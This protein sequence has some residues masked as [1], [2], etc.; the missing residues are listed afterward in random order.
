[1]MPVR[2]DF[3]DYVM[4]AVLNFETDAWDEVIMT[5]DWEPRPA[6]PRPAESRFEVLPL[7][8]NLWVTRRQDP[9]ELARR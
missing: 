1:M 4:L 5:F 7:R 3:T 9:Y 2:R 8:Q 6:E